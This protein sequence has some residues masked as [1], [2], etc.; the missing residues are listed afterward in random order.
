M[1]NAEL[2]INTLDQNLENGALFD[3]LSDEH[4]ASYVAKFGLWEQKAMLSLK[5]RRLNTYHETAPRN[6]GLRA[7]AR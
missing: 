6:I 3:E 1:N 5:Q 4:L 7:L 2:L